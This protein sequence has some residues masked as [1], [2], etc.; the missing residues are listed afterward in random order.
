MITN[1]NSP[2]IKTYNTRCI[3]LFAK[4]CIQSG[5]RKPCECECCSFLI[6]FL[7]CGYK[8]IHIYIVFFK[9]YWLLNV[10]NYKSYT[11]V[12]YTFIQ[13]FILY[14]SIIL[15]LKDIPNRN[16]FVLNEEAGAPRF[17]AETLCLLGDSAK[18]HAALLHILCLCHGFLWPL[19]T[20]YDSYTVTLIRQSPATAC[21]CENLWQCQGPLWTLHTLLRFQD[22]LKL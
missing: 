11:Q 1:I 3:Y 18:H 22:S 14:T 5:G 10:F 7:H 15:S 9:S 20:I 13:H 12:L 21:L 2:L 4:Y 19:C 17:E 8:H 6:I 16:V